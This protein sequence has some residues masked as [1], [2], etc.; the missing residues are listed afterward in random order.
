MNCICCA[1]N[2]DAAAGPCPRCAWDPNAVHPILAG[3]AVGEVVKK[4]YIL[5]ESLGKGRLGVAAK[6]FDK[7]KNRDVVLKFIHPGLIPDDDAGMRFL[8]AMNAIRSLGDKRLAAPIE[9]GR[10][11]GRY[12]LARDYLSGVS[13]QQLMADQRICGQG[14]PFEEAVHLTEKLARALVSIRGG[15]HGAFSPSKIWFSSDNF[16]VVDYGLASALPYVALWHALSDGPRAAY[17]APEQLDNRPPAPT[18]DVYAL[19]VLLGEMLTLAEFD[20]NPDVFRESEP[21]LSRELEALIRC[22]LSRDT[23]ARYATPSDFVSALYDVLG[24][25]RSMTMPPD[26]TAVVPAAFL[27]Q[28][29]S[30]SLAAPSPEDSND[31]NADEPVQREIT[32]QVHLDTLARESAKL[33]TPVPEDPLPAELVP[34]S[35]PPFRPTDLGALGRAVKAAPAAPH[36]APPPVPSARRSLIPPMPSVPPHRPSQLPIEAHVP[37]ARYSVSPVASAAPMQA[38][39]PAPRSTAAPAPRTSSSSMSSIP[40]RDS[41]TDEISSLKAMLTPQP[42]PAMHLPKPPA[43]NK[44]PLVSEAGPASEKQGRPP[45][46]STP[47]GDRYEGINPR[48]LRAAAK[49]QEAQVQ[50][51]PDSKTT[52]EE[53]EWRKQLE[54]VSAGSVISFLPPTTVENPEKVEGFPENQRNRRPQLAMRPVSPPKPPPI[55]PKRK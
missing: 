38:A 17:V 14:F 28:L 7:E 32:K 13:L 2:F 51:P 10:D 12:F 33:T 34:G 35:P 43:V 41:T 19:G 25:P 47:A 9:A 11:R 52:E 20:G 21:D 45:A 16:K 46:D 23:D 44:A 48:F 31:D 8:T 49:L 24:R 3:F 53:D 26:N 40:P 36:R 5:R 4:R 37:A 42:M 30:M 1:T 22:A 27:N 29:R 50:R 54:S 39:P 55:P 18:G 6:A 15:C